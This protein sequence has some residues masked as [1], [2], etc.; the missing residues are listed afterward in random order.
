MP[1]EEGLM[2]CKVFGPRFSSKKSVSHAI[3][4]C[5]EQHACSC[6]LSRGLRLQVPTL[7]SVLTGF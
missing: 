4:R 6:S 3:Y 1:L 5:G 2:R 7:L